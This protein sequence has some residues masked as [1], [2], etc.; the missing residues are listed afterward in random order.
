MATSWQVNVVHG[1]E[2]F[3]VA[4][5]AAHPQHIKQL[6]QQ[7][8]ARTGVAPAFQRLLYRG[9]ELQDTADDKAASSKSKKP[10][11]PPLVD[12]AKIMLLFTQAYHQDAAKSKAAA[13]ST[14]PSDDSASSASTDA[15]VD[16]PL[17]PK[18]IDLDDLEGDQVLVQVLRGKSNYEMILKRDD[19]VLAVKTRVGG[20]LGL[21]PSAL[22]LVVKGKTP[23][24]DTLLS[25]LM[26][27]SSSAQA[28]PLKFMALLQA[29]QHVVMEKEDDLR[30]LLN[31]LTQL[32]VEAQRTAKQLERNFRSHEELVITIAGLRD[33]T[34]RVKGNLTLLREH[35]SPSGTNAVART[36]VNEQ[37]RETLVHA[38]Q[39]MDTLCNFVESLLDRQQTRF[40]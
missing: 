40:D 33:D 29:Q 38:L 17:P 2:T 21:V 6:K 14:T 30:L 28:R 10:A 8:A 7:I 19:T 39:E 3:V 13:Q 12:N 11:A 27:T 26:T 25:D 32:Q 5:D 36:Q 34:Q 31:E 9:K 20:I 15:P 18:P 22:R 35:L 24:D 37:T 23:A 4:L 1:K 16:A